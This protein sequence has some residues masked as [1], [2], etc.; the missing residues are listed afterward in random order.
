MVI[1]NSY[2]KLP[3]GTLSIIAIVKTFGK[4]LSMKVEVEPFG[5]SNLK[6][7]FLFHRRDIRLENFPF[8]PRI[9]AMCVYIYIYIIYV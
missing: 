2:V 5:W 9:R 4:R 8:H 3:E 7:I 6:I 1:F